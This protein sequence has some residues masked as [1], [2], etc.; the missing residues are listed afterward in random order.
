MEEEHSKAKFEPKIHKNDGHLTDRYILIGI[1][2]S[3]NSQLKL[4]WGKEHNSTN[5][6]L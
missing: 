3:K 4:P 5:S 1:L 2:F 6:F